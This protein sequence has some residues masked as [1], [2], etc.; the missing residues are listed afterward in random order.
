MNVHIVFL[1]LSLSI[2][3]GILKQSKS[4]RIVHWKAVVP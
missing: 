2:F 3:L 4:R 1:S